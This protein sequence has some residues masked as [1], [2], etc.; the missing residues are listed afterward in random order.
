MAPTRR[1]A[2][3]TARG[4]ILNNSGV[5][6]TSTLTVNGGTFFGIIKDNTTTPGVVAIGNIGGLN[7]SGANTYSGGT[8]LTGTAGIN[9][10]LQVTASTAAG[11]GTIALN[12]GNGL[13]IGGALT[14]ANNISGAGD[15]ENF[16][17][18]ASVTT[19]TGNLSYTGA[20]LF[21]FAGSTVVFSP[22]VNS[23]LSG[24]IGT[25]LTTTTGYAGIATV[26]GGLVTK[27]GANALTLTGTNVYTGATAVQA[28]TLALGVGGNLNNTAISVSSGTTSRLCLVQ[29]PRRSAIPPLL[30][31]RFA[32]SAVR[33]HLHDGGRAIGNLSINQGSTFATAPLALNGETLNLEVNGATADQL[34]VTAQ[35]TAAATFA[36]INT[37]NII[38]L[39]TL[40]AGTDN[41][42][43]A[44][45]IVAGTNAF[46][47]FGNGTSTETL[48]S[49]GNTYVLTLA[50]SPVT[51]N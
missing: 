32:E 44:A 18:S 22:S 11:T 43:N 47:K 14:I 46:F 16:N 4:R 2:Q 48:V 13:L 36:G 17:G 34:T 35:G 42:V 50:R 23:T 51:S 40:T 19:L 1:S 38:G 49:G 20:T 28:G 39:G 25:I 5:A 10:Y 29:A 27:A 45:S 8:T 9:S 31:R 41:L 15:V 12:S 7:L 24:P 26:A 33:K 30:P 37:V 6:G 3:L 21:R